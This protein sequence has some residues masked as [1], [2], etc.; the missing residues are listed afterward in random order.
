MPNKQG[1]LWQYLD[2]ARRKCLLRK[3]DDKCLPPRGARNVKNIL[4]VNGR[5]M[6]GGKR[7]RKGEEEVKRLAVSGEKLEEGK[8]G[9]EE[10]RKWNEREERR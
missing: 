10:E 7:K 3:R 8:D 9:R 5:T 6:A 1:K 2:G 4:G